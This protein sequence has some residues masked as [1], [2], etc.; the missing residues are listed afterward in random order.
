MTAYAPGVYTRGNSIIID[1]SFDGQ[2]CKESLKILPTQKSL[3]EAKRKREAILYD[4]AMG[5]FEYEKHFPYSKK[6]NKYSKNPASLITVKDALNDFL[7]KKERTCAYST[8]KDYS[9]AIDYHL[10]PVFGKFTLTEITKNQ[11][12]DWIETLNIS[13]KRINNILSPIRQVFK[14][15]YYDG[16][17]KI[18]PLSRVRFL[19][20]KHR[21]PKPFNQEEIA[22]ILNHLTGQERNLIQ[23]AFWSG[24][25]TSELIGLRWEDIDFENDRFYVRQA[26]VKGRVKETKT[27]A[28]TRT[29]E[30][31]DQSREALQLQKK[32]T[33][34]SERVFNDPRTNQPWKN[35]QSIR[36]RLW[37]STLQNTSIEYRSPYQTRHT[38]A[39]MMLGQ[40]K[41]P[42]WV[43]IQMGH[44]DWGMIRKHYGRWIPSTKA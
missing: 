31:N 18:D 24:L 14:D 33:E 32:Y 13:N 26:V 40:R 39:S 16:L 2:R 38:F 37:I 44:K 30:L 4:I 19:S 43:A 15:A 10:I 9:S 29:V 1:F 8:L 20:V 22:K 27:S 17:I 5:N 12:E 21:E 35:D 25:R 6:A 3:Q 41:D 36:K 23:F 11:V 42:M 7:R 34:S 28:G